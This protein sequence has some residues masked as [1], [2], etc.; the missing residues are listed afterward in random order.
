MDKP[1]E[2][3]KIP[4]RIGFANDPFPPQEE[5]EKKSF[6]LLSLL[7]KYDYPSLIFTKST[8]LGRKEYWELLHP[9]ISQIQISLSSPYPELEKKIEPNA[10]SGKERLRT[11]EILLDQ[12]RNCQL[13]INLL[14]QEFLIGHS[15]EK[16]LSDIFTLIEE[17]KFP[18]IINEII[19]Q[20]S[21]NKQ[22]S[23]L[24]IIKEWIF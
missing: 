4:L 17:R 10:P 12:K 3:K 21:T 24:P 22:E 23:I 2:K 8:F 20:D 13:R 9:E 11:L 7:N 16:Y 15:Y 19:F 6:Q 5:K 14:P 18:T 1:S